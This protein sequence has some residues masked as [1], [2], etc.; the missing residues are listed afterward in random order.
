MTA[1]NLTTAPN[2]EYQYTL[3]LMFE[4]PLV[5]TVGSRRSLVC[6]LIG[7]ILQCQRRVKTYQELDKEHTN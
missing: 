2:I 4:Q 1:E 6:F 7:R 5:F 3:L